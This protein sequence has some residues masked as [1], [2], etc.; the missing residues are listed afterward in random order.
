[1]DNDQDGLDD[2]EE[3]QIAQD[4]LPFISL[5][6][7]ES[8]GSPDGFAVRVYPH[9]SDTSSPPRYLAIR[10]DHLYQTDCGTNGHNGDDENI[11][12]TV[13][14]TLPPP[15]GIMVIA[16]I[17]HRNTPCEH[18]SWCVQQSWSASPCSG[19]ATCDSS[20]P[21]TI[22]D[23]YPVV[24]VSQNKHGDYATMNGCT[25]GCDFGACELNTVPDLPPMVNVGEPGHPLINN[26]TTQAF[27]NA[28]A[29]W[30]DTTLYNIDP[31][32]PTQFGGAGTISADM[33]DTAL[34]PPLCQ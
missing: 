11:A 18:D 31:W 22:R 9:P 2:N 21:G 14:T 7:G 24:Y 29:G 5:T 16:A 33:T 4:Y 23:S 15:Q 30:T 10:Y 8:C 3:L 28:D 20:G 12:I 26:L 34:E 25:F 19:Y 13:D 6:S 32:G 1:V 17:S 27:I